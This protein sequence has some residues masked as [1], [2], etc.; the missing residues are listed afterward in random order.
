MGKAV[1]SRQLAVGGKSKNKARAKCKISL[2]AL[3]FSVSLQLCSLKTD[4]FQYAI[5]NV[6]LAE[7]ASST[8]NAFESSFA[9]F[10]CT[11]HCSFFPLSTYY[12]PLYLSFPLFTF[13]CFLL[14]VVSPLSF[15][16]SDICSSIFFFA[17]VL[18]LVLCSFF[19][20]S[21]F[22][23]PL[24][25]FHCTYPFHFSLSTYLCKSVSQCGQG[26]ILRNIVRDLHFKALDKA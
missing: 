15:L 2:S 7:K 8:P 19:P 4:S 10:F 26:F 3:C 20:L 5:N 12:F 14:P 1:G 25:T 9:L 16:I 23:F 6:Q 11:C 13:H 24:T 21:T 22:F 18:V 17:L